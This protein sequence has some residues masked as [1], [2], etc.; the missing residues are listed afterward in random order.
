[1]AGDEGLHR[2]DV[3]VDDLDS[4]RHAFQTV[5]AG[6]DLGRA[7]Q[8]LLDGHGELRRQRSLEAHE[9]NP[10]FAMLQS[11]FEAVGGVRVYH[12]AI[13]LPGFADGGE[14]VGVAA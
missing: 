11:N 8:G 7:P 4:L 2:F 9:R 5:E 6:W 12:H 13:V 14:A 3:R 1:M 10:R